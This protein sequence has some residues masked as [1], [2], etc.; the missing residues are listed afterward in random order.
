ML[1]TELVDA[2]IAVVSVGRVMLPPVPVAV[3]V[4]VSDVGRV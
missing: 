2:V 4:D 1:P 3:G